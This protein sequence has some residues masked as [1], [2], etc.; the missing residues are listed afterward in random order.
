[1]EFWIDIVSC[2]CKVKETTGLTGLGVLGVLFHLAPPNGL[3]LLCLNISQNDYLLS[4][5]IDFYLIQML[6]Q[7]NTRATDVNQDN[8]EQAGVQGHSNSGSLHLAQFPE[9]SWLVDACFLWSDSKIWC[10]SHYDPSSA[11]LPRAL[12]WFHFLVLPYFFFPFIP[13]STPEDMNVSLTPFR[14]WTKGR[15]QWPFALYQNFHP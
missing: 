5:L 1:M 8:P 15:I 14:R 12:G 7:T 9:V 4:K 13:P 11:S 10:Q 2:C 3:C 6:N